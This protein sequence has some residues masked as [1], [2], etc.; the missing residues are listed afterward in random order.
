[1][2]HQDPSSPRDDGLRQVRRLSNRT[3]V[4]LVVATGITA[5]YFAHA[6]AGAA[7]PATAAGAQAQAPGSHQPCVTAPVATSGGSGVPAVK[8]PSS[9]ATG[10]NGTTRPAGPANFYEG[11]DDQ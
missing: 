2:D 11:R 7:R 6:T 5:G 4:A 10:Q 1:M 8:A 9:C 3:A